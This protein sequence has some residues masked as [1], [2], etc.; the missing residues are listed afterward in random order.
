MFWT[1]LIVGLFIGANIGVIIAGLL[2]KSKMEEKALFSQDIPQCTPME[3]LP[4]SVHIKTQP[5]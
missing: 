2:F 4:E 5:V 3:S 1:G